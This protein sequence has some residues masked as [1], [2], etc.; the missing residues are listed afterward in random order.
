MKANNQ[1]QHKIKVIKIS[2]QRNNIISPNQSNIYQNHPNQQISTQK[3][4]F[5]I[6]GKTIQQSDQTRKNIY[7]SKRQEPQSSKYSIISQQG[8]RRYAPQNTSNQN[9]IEKKIY[10][11]RGN[12]NNEG[13]SKKQIGNYN[14]NNKAGI[15]S[16][17]SSADNYSNKIYTNKSQAIKT[18]KVP[19]EKPY[20]KQE[21]IRG[22]KMEST[23]EDRTRARS[24][25]NE[26]KPKNQFTSAEKS[27]IKEKRAVHSVEYKRKTIY[28]GG[29]Y[30]NIQITHIISTIKPNIDKYNFHIFETLSRVELDKKPL[31]LTKIKAQIRPDHN[32]KSSYKSS[33]DGRV[34]TP[35]IRNRVPK[36]TIYQ[37]AAGIGMTDLAPDMI[38]SSLYKSGLLKMTKRKKPKGQPV[39]QIIEVF[40]SQQS[41]SS[42]L[43]NTKNKSINNKYNSNNTLNKTNYNNSNT[44]MNKSI[45]SSNLISRSYNTTQKPDNKENIKKEYDQTYLNQYN[46]NDDS[47]NKNNNL[48]NYY[49]NI[50]ISNN[51]NNIIRKNNIITSGK[52]SNNKEIITSSYSINQSSYDKDN[53]NTPNNIRIGYID[54]FK[55]LKGSEVSP[56]KKL[57]KY[58]FSDKKETKPVIT[59][60]IY[61]KTEPKGDIKNIAI[62]SQ[63]INQISPNNI[64]G[65]NYQKMPTEGSINYPS[66]QIIKSSFNFQQ[67]DKRSNVNT[68]KNTDNNRGLYNAIQSFNS[69]NN[70][71][72]IN[73]QKY[74][75]NKTSNIQNDSNKYNNDNKSINNQNYKNSP[76]KSNISI[77]NEP[78]LGRESSNT[79]PPKTNAI[80]LKKSS[81]IDKE[82]DS[83]KKS[84]NKNNLRKEPITNVN[85]NSS[86]KTPSKMSIGQK[87][88]G[89]QNSNMANTFNKQS[90]QKTNSNNYNVTRT[91]YNK[92]NQKSPPKTNINERYNTKEMP[93]NKSTKI[94]I[95]IEQDSN[96]FNNSRYKENQDLKPK[97]DLN[98][99]YNIKPSNLFNKNNY[100][101][102][103]INNKIPKEEEQIKM[104]TNIHD[105]KDKNT[106][107]SS[108]NYLSPSHISENKPLL[109]YVRP[110]PKKEDNI[111]DKNISTSN[112]ENRQQ[113]NYTRPETK[114]EYNQRDNY[115][116]PT[117]KI[118]KKSANNYVS[119]TTSIEN[120]PQ[121]NSSLP[122]TKVQ[123][124]Q[125]YNYSNPKTKIENRQPIPDNYIH[126]MTN[127]ETKSQE[128]YNRPT[129]KNENEQIENYPYSTTK[130]EFINTENINEYNQPKKDNISNI[131]LIKNE[132]M[133][134][135][136]NSITSPEEKK[137]IKT[138]KNLD[139]EPNVY[140]SS[141]IVSEQKKNID[142]KLLDDNKINDNQDKANNIT[143]E[144]IN[145]NEPSN[146]TP[147]IKQKPEDKIG[148]N[149]LNIPSNSKN[150]NN[151]I[152]PTINN[153]EK[154]DKKEEIQ[155]K[156]KSKPIDINENE[157]IIPTQEL[158]A[159]KDIITPEKQKE[160][161][162][163]DNIKQKEEN[164]IH[165]EDKNVKKDSY[166]ISPKI[167]SKIS[168][169]YFKHEKI[170]Q[171]LEDCQELKHIF[172][173]WKKLINNKEESIKNPK[174][175]AWF[176]RNC[177]D[178]SHEP[179]KID[180]INEFLHLDL[181]ANDENSPARINNYIERMKKIKDSH[182]QMPYDEWFNN[183]CEKPSISSKSLILPLEQK[184]ILNKDNKKEEEP[185]IYL[186]EI[187]EPK[188]VCDNLTNEEKEKNKNNSYNEKEMKSIYNFING[189]K[190]NKQKK[191]ALSTLKNIV[192][193]EVKR[194][195]IN[196]LNNFIDRKM[197]KETI[198]KIIEKNKNQKKKEILNNIV[199]L[200]DSKNE[201]EE[202]EFFDNVEHHTLE[203]M[204]K[205]EQKKKINDIFNEKEN[206]NQDKQKLIN[207][208]VDIMNK[209]DKERKHEI[210]EYLR[211]NNKTPNNEEK[212]AALNDIL[213]HKEEEKGLIKIFGGNNIRENKDKKQN[214]ERI[215]QIIDNLNAL[216]NASKSNI[217]KYMKDTAEDK[218]E[219]NKDLDVILNNVKLEEDINNSF[220][221]S[222]YAYDDSYIE[223]MEYDKIKYSNDLI[224]NKEENEKALSITEASLREEDINID[225]LNYSKSEL[226][227][228]DNLSVFNN[229]D[230]LIDAVN[231]I[232]EEK[233]NTKKK[234]D[235]DEFNFMINGMMDDL[236][237]NKDI[238]KAEDKEKKENK[239][240]KEKEEKEKIDSAIN[241]IKQLNKDDQVKVIY[242]LNN[243]SDND[244]KKKKIVKNLHNNIKKYWNTQK[245]IK[246]ILDKQKKEV[247]E[248]NKQKEKEKEKEKIENNEKEEEENEGLSFCILK[249]ILAGKSDLNNNNYNDYNNPNDNLKNSKQQE[250]DEIDNENITFIEKE[251]IDK[252][253]ETLNDL[254]KEEQS[255]IIIKLKGSVKKPKEILKLNK[256]LSTLDYMNKMKELSK[257]IKRKPM[258]NKEDKKI[259][260]KEEA[261]QEEIESLPREELNELIEGFLSDLYKPKEDEP[262][263]R[264]EKRELDKENEEKLKYVAKAIN[265]LNK[266]DKKIALQNLKNN[267]DDDRKKEHFNKLDNL[268]NNTNN[269]K[270]Y[271]KKLINEKI[272]E[273]KISEDNKNN[274]LDKND[275]DNLNKGLN[276]ELFPEEKDIK[277]ETKLSDKYLDRINEQKIDKAVDLIKDLNLSQKKQVLEN[278]KDKAAE[279]KNLEKFKT[280]ITKLKN[281]QKINNVINK[282]SARQSQK[283]KDKV[284]MQKLEKKEKEDNEK[285]EKE[286]KEE[287]VKPLKDED[288]INV[289]ESVIN[290]LYDDQKYDPVN[291]VDKYIN[292][293]EKTENVEKAADM[294]KN[295]ND[296]DKDNMIKILNENADSNE[297]KKIVSC[298]KKKVKEKK[299]KKA[300]KYDKKITKEKQDEVDFNFKLI[301]A[302]NNHI[303]WNE[304]EELNEDILGD[305]T[306]Q[307]IGDLFEVKEH[308]E[309]DAKNEEKIINKVAS[310]IKDLNKNDQTKVL[311]S[312]KD[313]SINDETK[314]EKVEKVNNLVN[315]M[316]GI[317]SYLKGIIRKR[318]TEDH[319]EAK[320][321]EKDKLNGLINNI[322][323]GLFQGQEPKK[324]EEDKN[325]NAI[326][327]TEDGTEEKMQNIVNILNN[328][329]ENDKN[330]ILNTL[331]ENA[332]NE[333]NQEILSKLRK[334][335]KKIKKLNILV[336][337]MKIKKD[338]IKKENPKLSDED[339][340]KIAYDYSS[341]LYYKEKEPFSSLENLMMKENEKNKINDIA[342]SMKTLDKDDQDKVLK[343]ISN[344]AINDEQKEKAKKLTNIVSNLNNMK[345]YFGKMIKDK[346][347][348]EEKEEEV[349]EKESE[350]Y[351]E[352][353]LERDLHEHEIEELANTYWSD[354]DKSKINKINK[355][356]DI[357]NNFANILNELKIGDKEKAVTLLKAKSQKEIDNQ[358]EINKL[359]K[360]LNELN[361]MKL[362]IESYKKSLLNE[363]KYAF[364][365][366]ENE[367]NNEQILFQN[368]ENSE[369]IIEKLEPVELKQLADD[370]CEELNEEE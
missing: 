293:K 114:I 155:D 51:K 176:R 207:K 30:N 278:I 306:N 105:N 271:I 153:E 44:R 257:K 321:L 243:I 340:N 358:E 8:N 282:L 177:N 316:N 307:L 304:K 362:E 313:S 174:Y 103:N 275:M 156:N 12:L 342:I 337:N 288:F 113:N 363:N 314:K 69:N 261:S 157:N 217:L 210:L 6:S 270:S 83:N 272:Y 285:E 106:V 339:I 134:E 236:L 33:C 104:T 237:Q 222:A 326:E 262:K 80:D 315:N 332:K 360:K 220:N 148:S 179:T 239:E 78:N 56:I 240:E 338:E 356:D 357:T 163:V 43:Y 7:I 112:A 71:Y 266:N 291:K 259:N 124:N 273:E 184:Y 109:S 296:E 28:R 94:E 46:R 93:Y 166:E 219:K 143:N 292:E 107:N 260:E 213:L 118:E 322:I 355:L 130:I 84:N 62:I 265:S 289:T 230:E 161:K 330:K 290:Y 333:K 145:D 79:S 352:L 99:N 47:V 23:N 206:I 1:D 227:S 344:N 108:S 233:K 171:T 74:D 366:K 164:K 26:R 221:S 136:G 287:E 2:N 72:N 317:H 123:N 196:K 295:L 252:A 197:K 301:K 269:L 305:M 81:N 186:K 142:K 198:D 192:D 215:S 129:T 234:L 223:G 189:L 331:E 5:Y 162:I 187:L 97:E 42:K 191:K 49:N 336:S 299:K 139:N 225:D 328:L 298:F 359:E 154:L 135:L 91:S 115:A 253:A 251:R 242:T 60:N 165:I 364:E 73:Q 200:W 36:T 323:N 182:E 231:D 117:T 319:K 59:N 170:P 180:K 150:D 202:K 181:D 158:K 214:M 160:N 68:S 3:G 137:N 67:N 168:D 122:T 27:L 40:R 312:L 204:P 232:E 63:N 351:Q 70:N 39:I 22:R 203:L 48:S 209:F 120:K 311:K 199:D 29:E 367:T 50:S 370:L 183:H 320:E 58:N 76:P 283:D 248:E 258:I 32:A 125:Q 190:N 193:N 228:I 116:R 235:N 75:R 263:T 335:M 66:Q 211:E 369:I 138:K 303:L 121:K 4:T 35:I 111:S 11:N 54:N 45:N 361:D 350:N 100:E 249:S 205:E 280:I 10:V 348:K 20:E 254:E 149:N 229:D 286:K 92:S 133:N 175:V 201:K 169:E 302:F 324:I 365:D 346:I 297:K 173:K 119:P 276:E 52:K 38:N 77:N 267:I 127:I 194:N 167:A 226:K 144:N 318:I 250:K 208:L 308:P 247:K 25:L 16:L 241:S 277:N 41:S 55:P 238:Q 268:L 353:P 65:N 31:D 284:E 14:I 110:S 64:F 354:L 18:I 185:L 19:L 216:D 95:N 309:E 294:I 89:N 256:L 24:Y 34:I 140:Q 195:Q 57:D 255:K 368:K 244:E 218:E 131:T 151:N 88:E 53:Y 279:E 341:D 334:K 329:H 126:S 310:V 132:D 246:D 147:I 13:I 343:I 300:K 98:K 37:H 347:K 146:L 178:N 325:N 96:Q 15:A 327:E 61:A 349:K 128:I 85:I 21:N 159:L 152:K 224:D 90:P 274:E 82:K 245:L 86:Q 188:T 9:R 172:K 141:T 101:N 212:L 102:K 264:A 17:I 87:N 281:V 345:S